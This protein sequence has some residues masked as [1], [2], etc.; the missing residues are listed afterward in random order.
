MAP[1]LR[2]GRHRAKGAPYRVKE[3]CATPFGHF[4]PRHLTRRPRSNSTPTPIFDLTLTPTIQH[5]I[6]MQL[7]CA[8]QYSRATP[9]G[10]FISCMSPRPTPNPDPNSLR[11]SR[12]AGVVVRLHRICWWLFPQKKIR[13]KPSLDQSDRVVLHKHFFVVLYLY[14]GSAPRA[15]DAARHTGARKSTAKYEGPRKRRGL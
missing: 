10:R 3:P 1:L 15:A 2:T 6:A 8:M 11:A 13:R 12:P 9:F 5:H 7:Q 4:L 14:K